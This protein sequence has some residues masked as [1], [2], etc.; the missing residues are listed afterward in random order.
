MLIIT[1]FY[2]IFFIL[3]SLEFH[4][5]IKAW[6]EN[7]INFGVLLKQQFYKLAESKQ[8]NDIQFDILNQFC[9]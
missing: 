3:K 7:L 9:S 2:Q 5:S 4:D 1:S 6:R 8:L